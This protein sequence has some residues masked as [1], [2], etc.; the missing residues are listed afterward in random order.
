MVTRTHAC[1]LTL[2]PG[3]DAARSSPNSPTT[4]LGYCC[5][6]LSSFGSQA[7]EGFSSNSQPIVE[8]SCLGEMSR[9]GGACDYAP[10]LSASGQ[11]GGGVRCAAVS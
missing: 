9:R 3:I 8:R 10:G 1:M 11:H 2:V 5:S 6:R 4:A 7:F